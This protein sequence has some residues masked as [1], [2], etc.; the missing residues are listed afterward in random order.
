MPKGLRIDEE[1][2][3]WLK[4]IKFSSWVAQNKKLN[5]ARTETNEIKN[6][7]RLNFGI[8]HKFWGDGLL[9]FKKFEIE[10]KK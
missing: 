1:P 9:Q 4:L 8:A 7:I 6:I 3:N 2:Q 5:Y 10:N